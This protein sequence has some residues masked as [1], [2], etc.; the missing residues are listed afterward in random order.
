[1]LQM[2]QAFDLQQEKVGQVIADI[3]AKTNRSDEARRS[4]EENIRQNPNDPALYINYGTLLVNL[5]E[6]QS[7]VDNFKKVLT[8]TKDNEERHLTALF[9]L[10]A[11]YK[12]WGAHL[13]DSI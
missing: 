3:Y 1:Y 10:G 6:Y 12:N 8:L 2:V 9:N 13:Q 11:V 7:A 4:F 5:K